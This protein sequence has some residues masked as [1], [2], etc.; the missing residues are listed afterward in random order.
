MTMAGTQDYFQK[1]HAYDAIEGRRRGEFD[2]SM[3]RHREQMHQQYADDV[4]GGRRAPDHSHF[5]ELAQTFDPS[6]PSSAATQG[7]MSDA[8]ARSYGVPPP[9]DPNN[10]Q[11]WEK[12]W[13]D[14][15]NRRDVQRGR[16]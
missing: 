16:K 11:T 1:P 8:A 15:L 12:N 10:G 5:T 13:L 3:D 7:P 9:R 4:A 14:A 6:V 2:L